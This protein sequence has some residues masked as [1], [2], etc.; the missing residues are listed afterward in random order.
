MPPT[1]SDAPSSPRRIRWLPGLVLAGSLTFTVIA[2]RMVQRE[3]QLEVH[4]QLLPLALLVSGLVASVLVT[5]ATWILANARTRALRLA[6]QMT[7]EMRRLS[8]V[9]KHTT[10]AV[11]L[12]DVGQRV[13]WVNESF[14]RLTGYTGEDI[15]GHQLSALLAGP[16]TDRRT[17]QTIEAAEAAGQPFKGELLC[18]AK[19]GR[20][21]WCEMEIQALRDEQ[22]KLLGYMTLQ[23]DITERKRA[24]EVLHQEQSLMQALMD[25]LPD[26]VYFKDTASRFLRVNHAMARAFGVHD[27][28]QLVGKTDADFFSGEHAQ[29]ALNNEQEIIRTGQPL[30]DFE[31]METW[32]DGSLT[33]VSTTKMPLRD[34][35]GKI[36]GTCGI[37][38]NITERKRAE[39]RML[40]QSAA[41]DATV[42]SVVITDPKGTIQWVNPAF[43]RTTGYTPAEAIGQNPRILKSG[44]TPAEV[45]RKLWETIASGAMWRGKFHN[46]RKNG[47][48]YWED[49]TIS[50]IRDAKG[51]TTHYLAVKED[52]TARLQAEEAQ[53]H[54]EAQIEKILKGAECL[55]W[56][57]TADGQ[58][59]EKQEWHLYL[60]KSVLYKKI[61]GQDT[62]PG[63]NIL[64]TEEMVPEWTQINQ[65]VRNAMREGRPDFDQEFH[66]N[67]RGQTFCLHENVSIEKVGPASWSLAGVIIDITELKEQEEELRRATAAAEKA[68]QAKSAFLAMMSHEIR[69]PM[70][71]V[72]GMTS[73]LLDTPLTREQHEFVETIRVSG[74]T[75]LTI[76]NDILDFSK[77]ESGKLE[78]E[79]APFIL[80]EC[81]EGALDLLAARAAEKGIDLLYEINDGVPG[82]IQGDGARLR[83]ILV[84]L[85]G[86]AVKFTA[87]GEVVLS[88]TVADETAVARL[89]E[90][91]PAGSALPQEGV[92]PVTLLFSVRDTGIGITPEAI[93]R[94]FQSFTQADSSTTRRFG[95]TGL[96]LA[97]SKRLA[98]LMGGQMWAESEEGRGSTFSFVLPV[99]ALASKP[100]PY[101][102]AGLVRLGDLRVLIVDDNPTNCR[103]LNT[104]TL[105]WGMKPRTTQSSAEALTWI[106]A[107]EAFDVAILDMHMPGLDG[108]ELARAIRAL[109]SPAEL[110][111]MLL[112][113]IGN[114]EAGGEGLFAVAL[115]KPVKS[116]QLF[117]ALAGLFPHSR[118][119]SESEAAPALAEASAPAGAVMMH[120]LLAEDN[121]V[122]Q[123]VVLAMLR[124]LGLR[125]DV[126][127]NGQE[128]LEA[129]RRQHYDLILMDVQMPEMDG[130]EAT[131]HIVRQR[132]DP[133]QRPWIVALTA[134]AIEGDREKCLA[135]GMDDYLSK[136]LRKEELAAAIEH[137]RNQ[138]AAQTSPNIT[139]LSRN[140]TATSTPNPVSNSP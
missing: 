135:A 109:R 99:Q 128:V 51:G 89:A 1:H 107:G 34:G 71:G 15:K 133:A 36:I 86:N 119:P 93:D 76:I 14:T 19:G 96:G 9:A 105:R 126:A 69:T 47:E 3:L 92:R 75:L 33:W 120:L 42:N 64:W 87:H 112:S 98:N 123:K 55:L 121:A 41:L 40:L 39:Q 28:A 130:L 83:Q 88:V 72:I 94:L 103:I 129:V 102:Q 106:Q 136:P 32:P 116:S 38:R 113:S 79:N 37:S 13:E 22:A 24:V 65:A 26:N 29:Q 68:N 140:E 60:P 49:A 114:R 110:P 2:W 48:L 25:N 11:A 16:E 4:H 138:R 137:A 132:P 44:E 108:V 134:N 85:L 63:Q 56:L 27:P 21:Y 81:I 84:N 118:Q 115:T 91:A 12:A 31:E 20:K 70:N 101:Q 125:A 73:L 59:D 7:G 61:F 139:G 90:P 35:T 111:L 80:R 23:L 52:I 45:Y 17:L 57:A 66:V 100:R 6:E 30:M 97:I 50:P 8:L 127:A 74:D 10:S 53:R 43:T 77:I 124:K 122:N 5:A 104:L 62:V 131:R 58:P 46:K 78:L 54:S 95:G 18:Y 82:T 67:V 117:D